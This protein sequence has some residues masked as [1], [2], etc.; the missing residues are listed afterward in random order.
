MRGSI[1]LGDRTLELPF[2]SSKTVLLEKRKPVAV[3][4]RYFFHFQPA[5]GITALGLTANGINC[6]IFSTNQLNE[7]IKH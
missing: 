3:Y 6:I 4:I 7:N 2:L 1:G 5:F